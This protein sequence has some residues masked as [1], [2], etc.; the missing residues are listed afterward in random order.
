[1]TVIGGQEAGSAGRCARSHPRQGL[2]GFAVASFLLIIGVFNHQPP[3]CVC[4]IKPAPFFVSTL[5]FL[6]SRG[7]RP[8][9]DLPRLWRQLSCTCGV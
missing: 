1:L 6:G 8:P 3:Y 7:P 5:K 9:D 4:Y 2:D